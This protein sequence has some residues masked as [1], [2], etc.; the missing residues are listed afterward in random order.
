MA[1]AVNCF[2]PFAATLADVGDT[3]MLVRTGGGAVTVTLAVPLTP[4]LAAVTVYGPPAVLPALKSPLPPIVPPPLTVQVKTGWDA[5][6]A[7]NW[8]DA[9]AVKVWVPAAATEV[10][11]GATL[12]PVRV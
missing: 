8:S 2:V 3:L 7:P 9:L 5:R 1:V 4:P 12:M 6:T 11:G 10:E